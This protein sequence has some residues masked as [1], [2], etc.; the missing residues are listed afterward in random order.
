[1]KIMKDIEFVALPSFNVYAVL[2]FGLVPTID[3][4]EAILKVAVLAATLVYTIVRIAQITKNKK[5]N[6]KEK[7]N[8]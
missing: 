8:A 7:E 2:T 4:L 5:Q 1:M 6:T 3:V